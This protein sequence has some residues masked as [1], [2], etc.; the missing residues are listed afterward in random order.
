LADFSA[1]VFSVLEAHW[2][3]L[4]ANVQAFLP[5]MKA[6]NRLVSYADLQGVV[7]ALDLMSRY[8][9]L[10]VCGVATA[11]VYLSN[12]DSMDVLFADFWA[13]LQ[14]FVAGWGL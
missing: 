7:R 14:N 13:Q 5:R 4:P 2:R 10:P 11:T 6:A 12:K 3:V 9:S 8:T 1:W